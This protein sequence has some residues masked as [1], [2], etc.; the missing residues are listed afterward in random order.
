ML[1]VGFA[2]GTYQ[3]NCYLLAEGPGKDCVIIDPGEGVTEALDQALRTH[4]LNPVGI[5]ATH[6]HFD[7]VSCATMVAEAHDV[8]IRIH[9][10]DAGLLEDQSRVTP[11]T[12]EVFELAGLEI[13]VEAVPGHTPGSVLFRLD[14]QEGGRL[15]LTGD[16]LFAGSV[17]R[18]DRDGGDAGSLERSLRST[19]L[20][21]PDDTVVLPGH[22]P[23]TSI[24]RERA[25][26]P[27][28]ATL[29]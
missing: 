17:G 24:G 18:T 7:H 12:D 10:G 28:L 9:P 26:N 2:T 1:V 11:L 23:A 25:A 3:A 22:G 5:L 15:V 27:F 21:L 20:A 29:S 14:S 4:D 6:G 8:G 13:T 16:T 19:V